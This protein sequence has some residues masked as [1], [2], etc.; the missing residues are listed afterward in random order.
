MPRMSVS[1]MAN[2]VAASQVLR[3]TVRLWLLVLLAAWFAGRP[4]VA[5]ADELEYVVKAEFIERFTRFIDWPPSAFQSPDSPFVIGL[6]KDSPLNRYIEKLAQRPIKD[7]KAVVRH[8]ESL[9]ELSGCHLVFIP[10]TDRP[11][12]RQILER[13]S[14]KPTLTVSD[15]EGFGNEGVLIN[16]YVTKEGVVRF[17]INALEMKRSGLKVS[18]QLLRIARLIPET[19]P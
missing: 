13:L 2:Q 17:E 3:A 19:K 12:L 9:A 14:N 8:I 11:H 7:R 15:T 16:L 4:K 1:A 6:T 18:S 5:S 10:A